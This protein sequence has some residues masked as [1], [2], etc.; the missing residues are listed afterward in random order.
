VKSDGLP[1]W[2]EYPYERPPELGSETVKSVRTLIVGGGPVGL[3]LA[4]DLAQK[5]NDV[6]LLNA[7]PFIP[8]GSKAIC[9]SKRSL[10][11]WDRL[12]VGERLVRKGVVWEKGKVFWKAD[13]DPI[14]EF[15]LLPI[16]GQ[17]N[18]A[19]VNIQQYYVEE[20]FLNELDTLQNVDIRWRNEVT[21]LE[22]HEEFVRVTVDTPDGQYRI[23]TEYLLACDGCRSTIRNLLGLD[24]EGRAFE[25][26]FL[27]V[28]VRFHAERPV[29]RWFRFDP[30]YPGWSSLIHK[31]PDDVWRLDFQLGRDIDK[32]EAIKPE[33]AEPYVRGFLGDDIEFDYEWISVYTFQCRRL[34]RLVHG[35]VFFAGDS[36]H[37][38]SPFGARGCNGGYA[39]IDNL[40]WKLDL[41]LRGKAPQSLLESYHDEAIVTANENILSSSRTSDFITPK[42][43]IS[44]VFRDAVLELAHDYP[45]ARP[46]VNS[47]RLS[48]PSSYPDS[49]LN[50]RQSDEFAGGL[51]PGSPCI[52]APV[53]T[54]DGA[55]W[56]LS[57]LGDVFVAMVF[58]DDAAPVNAVID[59]FAGSTIPVRVLQVANE[60]GE[61]KADRIV[62]HLGLAGER[63]G[64]MPGT[65]YLV[66]PDQYVAGRWR[67][68]DAGKLNNAL[69]VATANR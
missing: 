1:V 7:L 55:G 64:A 69:N 29:E 16:K 63:Y 38:V 31:Q 12:G 24:L 57:C 41:V 5:G 10:D 35:R 28:D 56:L 52:D 27:I 59:V 30:P 32:E 48:T 8:R 51:P 39:D 37:V 67:S 47:G 13:P 9:F 14:Y 18:P 11:I 19:F 68:M 26:N 46:F 43:A 42:S 15:D 6:T 34:A 33:N 21:A 50:D 53:I 23:D 66:R 17:K 22:T 54:R 65:I 3:A 58:C 40:A 49:P 62:D 44:K 20:Y 2:R 25:E 4:V 45:F 36:A 61:R 60:S